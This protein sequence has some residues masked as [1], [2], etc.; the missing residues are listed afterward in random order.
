MLNHNSYSNLSKEENKEKTHIIMTALT[1][2][3]CF[4][5][6]NRIKNKINAMRNNTQTT[7]KE[8]KNSL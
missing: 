1:D 5:E 2:Y 6:P 4:Y 7:I 3:D 8:N